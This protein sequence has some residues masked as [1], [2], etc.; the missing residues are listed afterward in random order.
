MSKSHHPLGRPWE[1]DP[2]TISPSVKNC[3][4]QWKREVIS[5][6]YAR[7]SASVFLGIWCRRERKRLI[8]DPCVVWPVEEPD[9]IQGPV[10]CF[11]TQ[12]FRDDILGLCQVMYRNTKES[13]SGLIEKIGPQYWRIEHKKSNITLTGL[14]TFVSDIIHIIGHA[15]C[16]IGFYLPYRLRHRSYA[17]HVHK[18]EKRRP[19]ACHKSLV[20]IV[21]L[22]LFVFFEI[23]ETV[24]PIHKAVFFLFCYC[25][26]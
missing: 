6:I 3:K 11:S 22:F 23:L 9:V 20:G 7:Y 10:Q 21:Q 19:V 12:V 18:N 1:V 14:S 13:I 25:A 24:D 26:N 15:E 8:I 4:G 16:L 2:K 17:C 5:W